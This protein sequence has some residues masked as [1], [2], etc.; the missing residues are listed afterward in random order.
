[1]PLLN[2]HLTLANLGPN[3]RAAFGEADPQIV[4]LEPQFRLYKLSQYGLMNPNAR[5]PGPPPAGGFR[6]GELFNVE[7]RLSPW[8]SPVFPYLD[9]ELGAIGRFLEAQTNGVVMRE[10]VRFASAVSLDWNDLSN[11]LEVVTL[12]HIQCF[13]GTFA[14][15][16]M[17]SPTA[18]IQQQHNALNLAENRGV[19][20][21]DTLG[22]ID[23]W[24]FYIPNL[25]IEWVE[26]RGCIPAHNMA[27]LAA[28]LN[29]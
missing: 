11:Y 1:M 16:R 23:A 19:H 5:V 10:M 25:T 12:G 6:P 17:F 28:H 24:Q 9:D 3:E 29:V 4:T 8:W 14:P 15:Q 22:G 18:S 26:Q 7:Q 27:A 20:V 21:P 2:P 13:W